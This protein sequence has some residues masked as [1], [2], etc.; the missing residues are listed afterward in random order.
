MAMPRQSK[1]NPTTKSINLS[2][3]DFS[4][5][6]SAKF[7]LA[8][9]TVLIGPQGS[10]KSLTIKLLYFFLDII[11]RQYGDI[12]KGVDID[13]FK[14][15]VVRLFK[16]WFPVSAWGKGKFNITFSAGPFSVRILRR[17]SKGVVSDDVT[18]TF[19]DFFKHQY[20]QLE[21]A[22]ASVKT[23]EK[24]RADLLRR[25]TEVSWR[26]REKH[27]STLSR[28]LGDGYIESQ[29][30]VPA[31]R[32][33]F[34]S[35]GRLVAAIEQGSSLDPV[36]IKFAKLF[37]SLRDYASQG[38]S[39]RPRPSAEDRKARQDVMV[40][41][42]GGEIKFER[43]SE[44]VE[45]ADGRRVPFTALSSG[46]QELL[47]MWLLIDFF[48]DRTHDRD[49]GSDLFYIEEPEAH[50]FP[51]AQS[52]LMDFLI[53]QLV[54]RRA[55]RKLIITTHSPYILSKLNTFLKAGN[56]ARA[57]KFAPY[58]DA[59]VPRE[60]WLTQRRVR[61]YS[62]NEGIMTNLMD[63]DGLIDG[64]Y[65]D[66]VSDDVSRTFSKLLDIEFPETAAI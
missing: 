50:L 17:M 58:V 56:L 26:I 45:T 59:V 29:T 35:I 36:T 20:S 63:E 10:G 11:T 9:V 31:G 64:R 27:A 48:A 44:Y 7:D 24:D 54:S 55:R 47:P 13:D 57:K 4:C 65:I 51:A 6:K 30:F 21:G 60:C 32:A 22:Y 1:S 33:F 66:K 49:K 37:A 39:Y 62:I 5:I 42:F 12:E 25:S 28:E 15:D 14:K 40:D 18:V 41:L 46:Q 34:T 16:N 53:G 61:A 8:P 52:R 3:D 19:S 2:I 23:A 43:E 38:L